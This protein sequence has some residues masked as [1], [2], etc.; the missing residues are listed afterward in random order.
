MIFNYLIISRFSR[1]ATWKK[2]AWHFFS[3][4]RPPSVSWDTWWR[5][6]APYPSKRRHLHLGFSE[7]AKPKVS[8]VGGW[9][10]SIWTKIC[11]RQNGLLHLPRSTLNAKVSQITVNHSCPRYTNWRASSHRTEFQTSRPGASESSRVLP[12]SNSTKQ[13]G[14]PWSKHLKNFHPETIYWW[15]SNTWGQLSFESST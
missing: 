2:R 14:S 4:L 5:I 13:P 7:Q 12:A 10:Q 3:N 8:P 11:Q 9:T 1:W 6:G 15:H